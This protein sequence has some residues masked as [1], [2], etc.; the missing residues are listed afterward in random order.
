MVHFD[1]SSADCLVLTLK[2]GLLS[3]V[4]HDLKIRVTKFVIII[5]EQKRTIEARF[6]ANSLRVVC[7]MRD[8][9]E[10][11]GS[12]STANMRDIERTIVRDVLA[13]GTYPEIRFV[14]TGVREQRGAYVIKGTLTL[15]GT[16]RPITVR[17]RLEN[18]RY[19][20]E[21]RVYQPDFGIRPYSAMLGALKVQADVTVRIAIP[22]L[23]AAH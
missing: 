13:S 6:D 4:A 10:S 9:V 5:D 2:E 22:V 16:V 17:A 18:Q 11:P 7:A 21:A 12:L 1:A 15:H 14:S 19:V 3:A 20:A 23:A 8:G